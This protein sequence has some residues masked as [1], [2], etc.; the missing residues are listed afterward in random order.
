VLR[1]ILLSSSYHRALLLLTYVI[2]LRSRSFG[3][4]TWQIH[5]TQITIVTLGRSSRDL[6]SVAH[7]WTPKIGF[8]IPE[9]VDPCRRQKHGPAVAMSLSSSELEIYRAAA[10]PPLASSVKPSATPN[11][12][13]VNLWAGGPRARKPLERESETFSTGC[14]TAALC[15]DASKLKKSVAAMP[16]LS[17]T[18][19]AAALDL[20][21]LG[22]SNSLMTSEIQLGEASV[23]SGIPLASTICAG[24]AG[25]A[26]YELGKIDSI[27]TVEWAATDFRSRGAA[28]FAPMN[29]YATIGAYAASQ[30]HCSAMTDTLDG[31]GF[32][33]TARIG[34]KVLLEIE[35]ENR[36]QLNGRPLLV[37][38]PYASFPAGQFGLLSSPSALNVWP[39]YASDYNNDYITM[40]PLLRPEVP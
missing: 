9:N 4:H 14:D 36:V 23:S 33:T 22:S 30:R 28:A 12:E 40:T 31:Y 37:L 2:S 6:C 1:H 25:A 16:E 24:K 32:D 7:V 10:R 15:A 8:N 38:P 3:V 13:N 26:A 35:N 19:R 17:A 11:E 29:S 18:P 34:S 39:N 27:S 21:G 5:T 20:A